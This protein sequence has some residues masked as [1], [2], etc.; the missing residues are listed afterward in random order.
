VGEDQAL[1]QTFPESQRQGMANTLH[2]MFRTQAQAFV[3]TLTTLLETMHQRPGEKLNQYSLAPLQA[4]YVDVSTYMKPGKNPGNTDYHYGAVRV[5]AQ[6]ATSAL[7]NGLLLPFHQ[8]KNPNGIKFSEWNKP[9]L[10]MWGAQD[11]MMP[12]NQLFRFE[13]IA[14]AVQKQRSD[15]RFFVV[16]TLID[17]AGHFAATDQPEKTA[18]A[19]LRFLT[20]SDD[21]RLHQPYLGFEGIARQDEK[22]VT[23]SFKKILNLPVEEEEDSSSDS[24]D[25][26][27]SE[28]LQKCNACGMTC[29]SYFEW[30]GT[31]YYAC[32]EECM[33]D[34]LKRLRA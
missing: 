28:D 34:I 15:S 9:V 27:S 16:G 4:P 14:H 7:G 26:S 32:D 10:V 17:N 5:L 24:E 22:H 8:Q 25:D 2:P 6:Q 3:G 1:L 11:K 23:E 19:I 31:P 30:S 13:N 20:M 12:A 33:Q 21:S 18:D 29:S